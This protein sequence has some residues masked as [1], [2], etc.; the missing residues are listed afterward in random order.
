MMEID[1]VMPYYLC[2]G[3]RMCGDNKQWCGQDDGCKHT[4]CELFAKNEESVE[5]FK[6]FTDSFHFVVDDYGKLICTEKEKK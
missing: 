4:T 5:L 3:A 6:R 1:E 2:N